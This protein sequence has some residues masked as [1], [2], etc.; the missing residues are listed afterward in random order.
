MRKLDNIKQFAEEVG[1]ETP[2]WESTGQKMTVYLVPLDKLFYNDE[3]GRISTSISGDKEINPDLNYEDMDLKDYN[4]KIHNF[5]KESNNREDF[6]KTYNDIK[7]KGQIRPGVVLFDGRVVS[8]NRRFTVLRELY[9]DT[10]NDKFAYFKCFIIEK[11]LENEQDRKYIKTIER[12]TQFGVDEKVDYDP[13][14]RLVDIYYDLIAPNHIWTID[15]YSKKLSLKKSDV[16]LMYHK[17]K[18]I[19]DFLDYDEKPNKFHIA[20]QLKMDGPVQELARLYKNVS[21]AEWNRI[22]VVFYSSMKQKGDRTRDIRGLIKVYNENPESFNALIKK[23]IGDVEENEFKQPIFAE[24]KENRDKDNDN[25]PV[26]SVL[27]NDTNNSIFEAIYATK[28]ES[29]RAEKVKKV[30]SYIENFNNNIDDAFSLMNQ[31]EINNFK[32]KIEMLKKKIND[33]ESK[34]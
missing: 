12:L 6:Q 25:H 23:C 3:N 13:I 32:I 4:N 1:I 29:N 11:N 2:D 20:R 9:S 27:S 15:E 7:L 31:G 22:R 34:W 24:N 33:I 21:V 30:I 18:I 10:A 8:G 19:A 17:A 5:V 26:I 28:A 14:S 16:E